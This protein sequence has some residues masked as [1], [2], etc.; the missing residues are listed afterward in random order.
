[1]TPKEFLVF[2]S[3]VEYKGKSS[4]LHTDRIQTSATLGNNEFFCAEPQS[5]YN[6]GMNETVCDGASVID[7][8]SS[9]IAPFLLRVFLQTK[10][11]R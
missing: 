11:K 2:Y 6:D 5:P 10:W 7:V 4:S 9:P 3:M 1:M 8:S